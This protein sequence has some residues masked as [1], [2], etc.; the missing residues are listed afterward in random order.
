[1]NLSDNELQE[2]NKLLKDKDLL[3]PEFRRTVTSSG[4]N[5]KW[6]QSSLRKRNPAVNARL[7]E[8][9]GLPL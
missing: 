7:L 3:L 4:H 5:Y 6:L 9:L 2:L 1:M 8:L